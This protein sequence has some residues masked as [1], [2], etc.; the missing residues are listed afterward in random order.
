MIGFSAIRC[1]VM[2]QQLLPANHFGPANGGEI[3]AGLRVCTVTGATLTVIVG[4]NS[5]GI[6]CA[7][8]TPTLCVSAVGTPTSLSKA[9]SSHTVAVCAGPIFAVGVGFPRIRVQ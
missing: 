8:E 4:G 9:T 2:S 7:R 5:G 3:T 1:A 6:G